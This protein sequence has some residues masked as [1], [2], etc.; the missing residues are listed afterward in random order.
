MTNT[1]PQRQNDPDNIKRLRAQRSVY[2]RAKKTLTWQVGITVALPVCAAIVVIFWPHLK[3]VAAA[4]ALCA[5]VSDVA[6]IDRF[7]K[8][9]KLLAATIQEEFDCS[10]LDMEWNTFTVGPRP[11]PESVHDASVSPF[12]SD[13]RLLRD[14]Y[15]A[16]VGEVPLYIGRIICQRTNLVYDARL[17]R[18]FGNWTLAFV[19]FIA[20]T[21]LITGVALALPLDSLVLG[22]VVPIAPILSWGIREYYRQTDAAN[23]SD[24]LRILI[25][26]LWDKLV[27]KQCSEQ[28]CSSQAR[29]LQN[30]IFERRATAP[31]IFDW[32]YERL[33]PSMESQVAVGATDLVQTI[34]SRGV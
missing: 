19:C 27:A 34:K 25:Q 32:I 8:K 26:T 4:I 10:V 9:Q 1:I 7:Q 31:L 11:D 21:L 33:R 14:W 3:A 28:E 20:G 22:F 12:G 15:P 18:E 16:I 17:R 30:A 2:A 5:A 6:F 23:A 29:L 13:D 24:R